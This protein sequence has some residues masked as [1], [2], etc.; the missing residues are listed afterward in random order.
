MRCKI[1]IITIVQIKKSEAEDKGLAQ[2]FSI[3]QHQK[4]DLNPESLDQ[5]YT[6]YHKNVFNIYFHSL[7]HSSIFLAFS[8]STNIYWILSCQVLYYALRS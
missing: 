1:I 2:N 7:I 6:Q 3:F 5:V 4:Q 8:H